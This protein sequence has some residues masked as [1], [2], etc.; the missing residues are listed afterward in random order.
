M[1]RTVY[2]VILLLCMLSIS[3]TGAAIGKSSNQSSDQQKPLSYFKAY[4][5]N[6]H[7][8]TIFTWT[9]GAHREKSVEKLSDPTPFHPDFQVPEGMDWKDYKTISLDAKA[10]KNLQALPDNHYELAIKNGYDFYVVTEHSHEPVLQPVSA[11]N[12]IWKYMQKTAKKYTKN[13][14]FIA[15]VGFEFSRNTDANGGEGHIN[16]INS[17][18]YGSADYGQRGP[19]PAWPEANWTIPQFYKWTKTAKPYAN[20]GSIAIGFNHPKN[21]QYGDWAHLDEEVVKQISTFEIHTNF[22]TPRWEA[23]VRALN[24]G[25][26]VSPI[27]VYDNHSINIIANKDKFPPTQVIALKLTREEI[28]RAM[29]ERRTYASWIRDVEIKYAVNGNIMGSTIQKS[30]AYQFEIVLNTNPANPAD[31]AK[32]IQILK[33]H[34]QGKDDMIVVEEINFD[35]NKSAISWKPVIKDKDAKFFLVRVYHESDKN[36]E[37]EFKKPGS[38]FAAPV[39]IN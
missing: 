8:H 2:S 11:E 10:Y 19:A 25:W 18:D 14:K 12:A 35:D 17:A 38:T 36:K 6:S 28:T 26:K 24:K 16:V 37:G 7:A 13:G 29:K 27:G 31:C 1:K 15:M 33:N 5:G 20:K 34:P 32:R 22:K 30:D 3:F 39:W 4:K 9:H 23:Y 21:D